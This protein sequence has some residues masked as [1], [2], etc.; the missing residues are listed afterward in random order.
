MTG[1][2]QGTKARPAKLAINSLRESKTL[3]DGAIERFLDHHELPIVEG[4]RCTFAVWVEADAV[5][6]RHRVVGLPDTLP[7]RRIENTNLWYAVVEI[8][9]D[10]RVEYQFEL[11]RGDSWERFNDPRNPRIARSPVGDSSV[12]YGMD[13]RVPDWALFDEEARPGELLEL[14]FHSLAQRRD[15]RVTLY[16]PARFHSTSRYPLLVVHDGGDF[17]EYASMK[18]VLDNLLHRLDMAE[19]VVA[20]TYPGERLDEYPNSGPHARWIVNELLP[21]LEAQFPLIGQ[22]SARCLMGSSFG[23]VASL[24][25]AV[26]YPE[27]FGSLLLQSGSFV[28]T[29]IGLDHGGG[30]AFDPVVKFINRYRARPRRVAERLFIS[31]GMYEPLIVANRSMLPVFTETGME[32]NYVES[33]DGHNWESWRDRLRDGLSW[34]FPGQQMFVYE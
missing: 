30:P 27:T 34:I 1:M 22:P 25:T 10:S 3:D 5:F 20:F 6:L 13:Y 14:Q 11:R 2:S 24:A 7:L 8:P 31:C 32:V 28:F 26:R 9:A 33:R 16:L 29:D 17:I 4:P 12:C 23:A 19:T 15:N 18:I 21:E